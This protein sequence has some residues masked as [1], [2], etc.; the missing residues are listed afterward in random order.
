MVLHIGRLEIGD[1]SKQ[2]GC[3]KM[4]L[5]KAKQELVMKKNDAGL[6]FTRNK[7]GL[8]GLV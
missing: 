6:E 5:T 2:K 7:T 4:V 1:S 8:L 3:F